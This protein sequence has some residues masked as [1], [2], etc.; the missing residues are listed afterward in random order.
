MS[1]ILDALRKSDQQRQR[2][3]APTLLAVQETA[4]TPKR[5]ALLGYGLLALVLIGAG[6]A[7]GVLRPWQ[8]QQAAPR[9]T[10]STAIKPLETAPRASTPVQPETVQPKSEPLLQSRAP[11]ETPPTQPTPSQPDVASQ[12]KAMSELTLKPKPVLKQALPAP[13]NTPADN[14]SSP[15]GAVTQQGT[16]SPVAQRETESPRDIPSAETTPVP[17]VM[18]MNELPASVRQALPTM[19]ISVH[20]YSDDPKVRLVG[21]NNRILHEGDEVAP[22]LK[23]EQITP[24]GMI[25]DYREYRISHGVK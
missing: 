21:I 8:S 17:A 25:L 14:A 22:G 15:A 7:I 19:A 23:L 24:E 6:I 1:Y 10:D 3:A 13:A 9:T 11:I 4:V 5:P 18:R 20:A 2:G 16:A 12:P